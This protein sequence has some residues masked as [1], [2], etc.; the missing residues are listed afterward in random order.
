L[1]RGGGLLILG[2]PILLVKYDPLKLVG[3][4]TEFVLVLGR[5]DAPQTKM[6]RLL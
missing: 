3:E 1:Q 2:I 6:E 4:A 5:L